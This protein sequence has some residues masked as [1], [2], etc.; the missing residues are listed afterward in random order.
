MK[1]GLVFLKEKDILLISNIWTIVVAVGTED[2]DDVIRQIES[3]FTYLESQ[4]NSTELQ[5]WIPSFE[6][7]RLKSNLTI[8]KQQVTSLNL[9]DVTSLLGILI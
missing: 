3:L 9:G 1:Q 2:Y 4:T 8:I 6:L 5:K 7:S